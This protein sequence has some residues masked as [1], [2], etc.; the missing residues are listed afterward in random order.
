MIATKFAFTAD[1][2]SFYIVFGV[3]LWARQMGSF[4]GM[5]ALDGIVSGFSS[6]KCTRFFLGT[7]S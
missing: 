7:L 3:E 1:N 5:E 6:L 2:T 4:R